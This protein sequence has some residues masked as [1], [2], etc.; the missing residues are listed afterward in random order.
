V[1][2]VGDAAGL[3]MPSNGGGIGQ[4]I[5]A[6][7]YAADAIFTN[8]MEGTPLTTYNRALKKTMAKPLRIS[9]RSKNLFWA[10]CR[11][12]FSTEIAM[13]LLGT[14]GLRRAV[15]CRPPLFII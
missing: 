2:A 6:G 7:K 15:D 4:A 14:N 11:N 9:K 12:D 5:I 13:R 3:V 8:K 1:L 10:F